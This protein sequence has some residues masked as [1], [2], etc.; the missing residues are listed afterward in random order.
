MRQA[1]SRLCTLLNK[2]A[3][4]VYFGGPCLLVQASHA[5]R[6]TASRLNSSL[7]SYEHV[8]RSIGGFGYGRPC[9]GPVTCLIYRQAVPVSS[10][11]PCLRVQASPVSN[12]TVSGL[13]L[14]LGSDD[15]MLADLEAAGLVEALN[16]LGIETSSSRSVG[17]VS[18]HGRTSH[19]SHE[20]E[21]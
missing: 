15:G 20:Y 14:S 5:S 9:R 8:R 13:E 12:E 18:P 2:Q 16:L 19:V 6:V 10:G 17:R 11:G 4:P 1:L 3:V 7:G 21:W